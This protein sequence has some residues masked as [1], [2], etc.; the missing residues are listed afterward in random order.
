MKISI[1]KYLISLII[2]FVGLQCFAQTTYA[3]LSPVSTG[4]I[5][6]LHAEDNLVGVSYSCKQLGYGK[7]KILIGDT[8]H[9]NAEQLVKISPDYIFALESAK[10]KLSEILLTK[11]KPIYFEFSS[12]E[13]IYDGIRLIAK[14]TN[15]SENAEPLI[16]NI[17]D[18]IDEYKTNEQKRILYIVQND[19]LIT[20]GNQ[21]FIND[22]INKSGHY[23]VTS[24]LDYSYPA[25][26]LEY[27]IKSNPDVVIITFG[28]ASNK[29][30][31]L[32]PNA[33][34]LY[35]SQQQRDIVNSPN[36]RVY[37]AVKIFSSLEFKKTP[38]N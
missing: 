11:T 19:P 6:D 24:E 26:T 13:D 33:Q 22:I 10:P 36:S 32:F 17:K 29:F 5:Y 30:K 25:I 4:I 28:E 37:E 16:Q 15:K 34:I 18:K 38:Q 21:S 1:F 3:S 20:V 23:S 8:F 2:F 9:V 35:L 14:Y 27:A 31:K 12:I 7:D